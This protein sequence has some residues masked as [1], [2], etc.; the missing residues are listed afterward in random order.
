MQNL[1][2]TVIG[3]GGLDKLKLH[4]IIFVAYREPE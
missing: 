2:N 4:K 3:L 1:E